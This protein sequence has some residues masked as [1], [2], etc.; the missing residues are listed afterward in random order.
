MECVWFEMQRLQFCL[1][2]LDAGRIGAAIQVR[3]NF[4]TGSCGSV[5]DQV[6]NALV[7]DQGSAA[8]VLSD[9]AEHAMLDL[10]PL[11]G[12]RWEMAHVDGNPQTAR[13]LLQRP[14]PQTAAAAVA[15]T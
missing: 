15:A 9:M 13:Q 3:A 10:V 6:D 2:H 5:G 4:Q 12:S 1:G 7:A 8:P 11:A 14:F